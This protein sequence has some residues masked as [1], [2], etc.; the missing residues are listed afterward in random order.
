ME[1]TVMVD[2]CI[3]TYVCAFIATV[4]TFFSSWGHQNNFIVMNTWKCAQLY[5]N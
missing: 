1:N 5:F 2:T 3:S 4:A